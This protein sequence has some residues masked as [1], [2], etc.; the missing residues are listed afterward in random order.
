[1]LRR[2]EIILGFLVASIF[3]A[4]VLGWQASYS[5]TGKDKQECYEA[6][7]KTGYNAGDCKTFWEK[8]TT[9]PI[10]LFTLV[11][12]FST[13]GLWVAT[14]GLYFA[15]ERQIKLAK[16][17]A[18][19]QAVEI[20]NQ[21][22]IAREANRAA[23]KSADAAIATERARLYVV[24]EHNFLRCVEAAK[25]WDGPLQQEGRLLPFD[26][27]PMAGIRFKNYGKTPAIIIEVGT[28]IVY[29]DTPPDPVWDVKVVNENI[30][31][32]GDH[33]EKFG[34]L[35]SGQMTMA[36]AEKIRTG[37]SNIWIYGYASY[38]DVFGQGQVHRFFQRLVRVNQ[39]RY[40]LQAYDYKHY[41][42]ST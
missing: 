15:G 37:E 19:Q 12:A 7:K 23:Q 40:V 42:Y 27:Q 24:I 5:P 4:A 9:E 21:I 11:L 26:I 29:A 38:E 14:I 36:Q 16:E 6:T 31:A 10:A 35:M 32:P 1:M 33:T 41:N 30:I 18:D 25:A 22:D 8:T 3:W 17:T 2:Y 20:Q 34:T 39:F 28:G 13:V